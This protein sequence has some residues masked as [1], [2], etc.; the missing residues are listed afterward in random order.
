MANGDKVEISGVP[1][2]DSPSA[3]YEESLRARA[4]R[5]ATEH[6]PV[7]QDVRQVLEQLAGR[8]P[9]AQSDRSPLVDRSQSHW[10]QVS[11]TMFVQVHEPSGNL[12]FRAATILPEDQS[13]N[14]VLQTIIQSLLYVVAW[15]DTVR[16]DGR[17]ISQGAP[18]TFLQAQALADIIGDEGLTILQS[19]L[20][21]I[22]KPSK[23]GQERIAA[24]VRAR[25][26]L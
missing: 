14:M 5:E 21:Q 19:E 9:S 22:Y 20:A 1:G 10:V 3:L 15:R 11:E 18:Q 24:I 13:R 16:N 12:T 2:N 6:A 7:R 17:V 26:N 23:W 4:A 8:Q 25:E